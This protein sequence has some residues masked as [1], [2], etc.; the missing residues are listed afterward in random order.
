MKILV[1]GSGAREHALVWKTS[2][3]EKVDK[4]FCA[5]GNGGI[6]SMAECVNIKADQ[7]DELADFAEQNNIGLTIVGPE[8]PLSMGIVDVFQSRNLKIFG[9]DKKA[10]QLESS[11]IFAKNIMKKYNVPTADFK[12]FTDMQGAMDYVIEQNRP[13]VIKADGLCAGKGVFVCKD[14]EEQKQAIRS[15]MEDKSFGQAGSTIMIEECLEGQEASM[16]FISDGEDVCAMASS[17]DHKRIFDDDKGPNT[18]GMGAYSPAPVV[19]DEL[20]E[21]IRSTV[22]IPTIKGM[23]KEGFPFVGVLYAGLMI[24]KQGPK[25]LEFNVRFGD[26]ETQAILPRLKSDLVDI[27]MLAVE[28]RLKQA[29]ISWDERACVCV[30]AASGGYPGKYEK[31]KPINGLENFKSENDVVVF[32]AGTKIQDDLVVT[33]GGRVLGITAL[34]DDI[35]Q[36]IGLAYKAIKKVSFEKMFYRTDIGKKAL[37]DIS[38]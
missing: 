11:K 30:V 7:V 32:H 8:V 21:Q 4:I 14:I 27:I 16:I 36:A 13:L 10:S 1:V 24:T 31:N 37:V 25:V 26:P 3:S 9:P 22:I 5:P 34:G 33:S 17:Q 20:F 23:K 18:G 38:A 2:Q 35:Q 28:G 29:E 15:I 6:A 19:T 12:T